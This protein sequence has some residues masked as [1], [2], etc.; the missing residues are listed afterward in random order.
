MKNLLL[1]CLFFLTL[2][3]TSFAQDIP[4]K[5]EFRAAWIAS[6]T[7]IDWPTSKYLTPSTQRSQYIS[8]IDKHQE[9]G[10][11]AV[12]VQ[13]RPSC[14]AFYPSTIEPWSEWLT[15]S[16][17]TAPNPYYDPLEFMINETHKRGIEF[18]A[19]FNPYRAVVNTSSSSVHSSHVS[20]K[21]PDW[22]VTYSSLKVLNPGLPQVR[23]YVVSVIM[24][25]V[26]RYNIDGVH[27]D[28]YFYPYPQTGI[29]FDDDATFAAYP[30]GFTNKADWR[31]DNVN[32]LVKMVHDSIKSIKPHVKFGISPFG[33]WK[34]G[35]PSGI[36]G[37]SAYD[38]IYCDALAWLQAKTVDYIAP[39]LY[40]RLGGPQDYTKLM[41]WWA[42]QTNGRHLYTGNA[43]YKMDP[44]RDN[45]SASEI[46]SQL[47]ENRKNAGAHGNI[48]F[49]SKWLTNNYKNI[50]DSLKLNYYKYPAL[51]PSMPWIDN[52]P[53]LPPSNIYIDVVQQGLSITWQKPS[54]AADGENAKRFVVYRFDHPNTVD[55]NN[56]KFI[57]AILDA[58]ETE[59]VDTE[60]YDIDLP[61]ITYVLTSLDRMNNES[62]PASVTIIP[63]IVPVELT[64]FYAAVEKN[65]ITLHW[66]TASE[67]NNRGFEIEKKIVDSWKTIG[68]KE[69]KG[70]TSEKIKYSFEDDLSNFIF[71]GTLYYR[72]KQ[73]DYNGTFD[74]SNVL[75]VNFTLVPKE[76]VL[77][78]NYPNPFN[79]V[80]IIKF[81]LPEG[82]FTTL[83][84]YDI[85][86]R[87]ATT[88]LSEKK[89]A[90]SY[91]IE[92]NYKSAGENIP[93]GVY[94]YQLICNR[95][96]LSKKMILT[97]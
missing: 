28:D 70:T 5:R 38:D 31:R 61:S 4:S 37:S 62:Q 48:Y 94:V 87:E 86:G 45:W 83:K 7:N 34:N 58:N 46:T 52:I 9:N 15:G 24:D 41:P 59:Y 69:G 32:L 96:V 57:K 21:H 27:F 77:E 60:P 44:A 79:P 1:T 97:K 54:Q 26:R 75:N 95:I 65:I 68:F 78:Q 25:V 50:G 2:I 20:I 80:T 35:V 33:I 3:Q 6:V 42:S 39:Q 91:S 92:F 66:E 23:D 12:V 19:W 22:I 51:T 82:G 30:R 47:M 72:L 89:E 88:L 11:N 55:I 84:V 8:I 64:T 71:N 74:Y 85:L 14:D 49:S 40:W 73:I 81:Q 10:M 90:G 13:I 16:Q 63:A 43:L 18:H 17:G 93:S 67:L 29:I 76:F 53:P 56:P 36:T